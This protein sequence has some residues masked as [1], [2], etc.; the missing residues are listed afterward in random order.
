MDLVDV[1][2]DTLSQGSEAHETRSG[3]IFRTEWLLS[4]ARLV[5][6]PFAPLASVFL[7]KFSE[8]KITCT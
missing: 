1:E 4:Q 5:K 6:L 3:I 2:P 7:Q 8:F